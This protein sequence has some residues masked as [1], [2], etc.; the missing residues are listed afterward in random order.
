MLCYY[1]PGPDG[2]M[3]Q[4]KESSGTADEAAARNKLK[5]KLAAVRLACKSGAAVELPVNRRVTVAQA[6]DDYLA[7]LR[8]RDAKGVSQEEFR[9]GKESPLREALGHLQVA[10]LRGVSSSG[11]SSGAGRRTSPPTPQS[12]AT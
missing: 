9:L 3:T 7:D 4:V 2:K 11:L 6:L 5:D 8:L 10:A 1:A 12:T